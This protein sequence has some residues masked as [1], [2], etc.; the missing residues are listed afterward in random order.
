MIR[1]LIHLFQ[2]LVC[3]IRGHKFKVILPGV[4]LDCEQCGASL[5]RRDLVP[6]NTEAQ[7]ENHRSL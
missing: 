1:K 2:K 7:H 3:R 6:G 4:L 5:I